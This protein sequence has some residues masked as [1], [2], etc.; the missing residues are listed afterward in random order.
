MFDLKTSFNSLGLALTLI[1]AFVAYRNS[2]LNEHTI[3]GG[4]AATDF[5]ALQVATTRKN[6]L[7]KYGIYAV[8]AGTLLQIAS[9]YIPTHA[10]S[11]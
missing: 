8:L 9:N 3:D 5:N 1:G 2:P 11:C 10:S 6:S 7:V 4:S